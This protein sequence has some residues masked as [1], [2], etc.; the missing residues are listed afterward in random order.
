[1]SALPEPCYT[2]QE[3]L[4]FEREAETKNEYIDGMVVAM[5]GASR[6]HS[7]IGVNIA[8]SLH[9]Q[10][11]GR[12][13]EVHQTDL[14]VKI[15]ADRQT[16]YSY[17]DVLVVCGE[18]KL[19]DNKFDTLLNPTVIIEVLSKS[20]EHF[21]RGEKFRRY[22]RLKSLKEYLLVSQDQ[23]SVEHYVRTGDVWQYRDFDRLDLVMR[24]PSI[25]CELNLSDVYDKIA[26]E[27]EDPE[28]ETEQ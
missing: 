11:K 7:L 26:F 3:Y 14:R 16:M 10:L 1:M 6:R 24:L 20:T 25:D 4:A 15:T 2:P 27:E 28:L 17:P 12:P 5:A 23:V 8:A 9:G 18:P 13:C 22:R 19:E 21:D